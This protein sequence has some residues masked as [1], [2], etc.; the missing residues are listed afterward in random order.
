MG[1]KAPSSNQKPLLPS[2][3]SPLLWGVFSF[4]RLSHLQTKLP[5]LPCF[6]PAATAVLAQTF[7]VALVLA[8]S[9]CACFRIMEYL[10]S[11]DWG[12]RGCWVSMAFSVPFS[13]DMELV[14]VSHGT[15]G[16]LYPLKCFPRGLGVH[17]LVWHHTRILTEPPGWEFCNA[18]L[19]FPVLSKQYHS[20]TGRN[21]HKLPGPL[22]T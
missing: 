1:K 8:H 22:L 20:Q 21:K 4:Q 5:G 13:C 7:P 16:L 6:C 14:G 12:C 17:I 15:H 18:Q 2:T 10:S 9:Q 19:E 3:L 11:K